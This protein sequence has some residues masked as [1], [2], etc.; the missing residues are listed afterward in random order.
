M[1][2]LTDNARTI[3]STLVTQQSGDVGA[4]LRIHTAHEEGAESR[5]AV[6]VVTEPEPT[7]QIID[8]G[9]VR[10]FLEEG[11][12]DS[13]SDKILDAGVGDGGS[14]SFALLPQAV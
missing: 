3:V 4:G 7:D 5:L 13:L 1:L 12:S 8:A 9:D 11:A 6:T 10:V 2:T 14:V